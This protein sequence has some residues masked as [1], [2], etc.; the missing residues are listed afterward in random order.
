MNRQFL[1]YLNEIKK[2]WYIPV[3]IAIGIVLMLI[4][5][6]PKESVAVSSMDFGTRY[7]EETERC[8]AEMLGGIDG[9]GDCIVTITLADNGKKE[10][11]RENG[12]VLVITDDDGNQQPVVSKEK[13]PDIAGV[14]IA[15]SGAES[16]EVRD[17]IIK[18][19]STVLGIG[20]NKIYVVMLSR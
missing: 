6:D 4:R 14:N 10:Y 16:I 13:A 11:V 5:I 8:I 18:S 1:C 12:S 2:F 7:V 19:V 3:M 20:T 9:A 15:C 17:Q